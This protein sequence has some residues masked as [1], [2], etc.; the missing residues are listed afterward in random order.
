MSAV[1]NQS[2]EVEVPGVEPYQALSSLAVA[3]LAFGVFSVLALLDWSLGV[4]PAIGILLGVRALWRIRQFPDELTGTGLAKAGIALSVVLLLTGWA[5][6]GYVTA[7]EVPDGYD[8]LSFSDLQI[9]KSSLRLTTSQ[10]ALDGKQ[11]YIKG[12]IRSVGLPSRKDIKEFLLVRDNNVCCFGDS[13]PNVG[14]MIHV[15]MGD[16]PSLDYHNG[17]VRMA[18]SMRVTPDSAREGRAVYHLDAEYCR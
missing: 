6:L 16:L 13:L 11:V 5:R 14:D 4:V 2:T 10:L 3:S 1:A 8:R 12:Y 7:T 15:K 18:G 9:D 17:V